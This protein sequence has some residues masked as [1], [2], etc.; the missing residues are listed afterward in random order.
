MTLPTPTQQFQQAVQACGRGQWQQAAGL[1][2]NVV[3][4]RPQIPEC[5]I[6]LGVVYE[7]LLQNDRAI[8]A[9]GQAV[10]LNPDCGEALE[11]YCR[12]LDRQPDASEGYLQIGIAFAE[13]GRAAQAESFFTRALALNPDAPLAHNNLGLLLN[14]QGRFQEAI[15]HF[16]QAVT[17]KPDY[18]NA[19]WN[20]GL[21][22]LRL[23]RLAEGWAQYAWRDRAELDTILV[24]QRKAGRPW[25]GSSFL[26]QRLLVRYE[27]GMGDAIQLAR[28]LPWVK[29]RGGTVLVEVPDALR[30]LFVSMA[31]IDQCVPAAPDGIPIADHDTFIFMM[32]LP[33]IFQTTLETIPSQV[34][35]LHVPPDK[36]DQW[37][38][39][40]DP[41]QFKVGI[42]WAGS[43]RHTNDI[44]R[45]CPLS[46]WQ[47]LWELSGVTW[48]S[49]QKGQPA[50]ELPSDLPIQDLSDRLHDFS[51]TAAAITHLDLIISVD[52]AV[53]HLAG[54]LNQ[55]AWGLLPF[56]P[57]WRWLLE[58]SD[59]PW[60]P[61]LRLFRQTQPDA[62]PGVL[63]QVRAALVNLGDRS[64]VIGDR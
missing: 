47:M 7:N 3:A 54:A 10:S 45:S 4:T 39:T 41:R 64:S 20:L 31:E 12:C 43:P 2:E 44:H 8:A 16:Q 17:L 56:V 40:F 32:D 19:H 61:S 51:D 24:S 48:Y 25:D 26:G 33:R 50:K 53:L 9:Y 23:G 13:T 15:E 36:I 63:Q 57:D 21:C 5:H 34:P 11:G 52:T 22:L 58:R 46:H 29:E 30:D 62:W 37:R 49:L 60:Y 42:V 38:D 14:Q 18:A 6:S 55:P 27:Q 35:Y 1:L 59:S 28:Y